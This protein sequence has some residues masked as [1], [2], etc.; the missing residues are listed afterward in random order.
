MVPTT[1]VNATTSST[2]TSSGTTI[3]ATIPPSSSELSETGVSAEYSVYDNS[4]DATNSIVLVPDVEEH[5]DKVEFEASVMIKLPTVLLCV[6]KPLAYEVY[7]ISAIVNF[8]GVCFSK[9]GVHF[10]K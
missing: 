8:L 2:A 5:L 9:E 3:A 7:V 6:Q 1:T 4:T 10:L